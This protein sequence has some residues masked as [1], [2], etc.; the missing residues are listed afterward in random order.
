VENIMFKR[1][2]KRTVQTAVVVSFAV[3]ALVLGQ[4][5]DIA[6]ILGDVRKALGADKA[7]EVKTLSMTGRTQ[8]SRPDGTSSEFA[9][10]MFMELPDKF[11][12]RDVVAAMG[13]T[14]IY[15]MSG[16]NGDGLINE[17][18]TPPSLSTGGAM[19]RMMPASGPG[20]GAGR[21]QTAEEMEDARKRQLLNHRQD[22]ARLALGLFGSSSASYPVELTYG[23]EAESADGKAY[24]V[25]VKGEGN[26]V[27]KLFIDTR[28]NLPLMLSWMDKEPLQ[29]T[30]NAGPGGG[31]RGGGGG[32]GGGGHVVMAGGGHQIS[33][34]PGDIERMQKEM[35]ER[36]KEAEAK[37]RTVEYRLFYGDYKTFNGV[38]LPTR[39]QRMIDGSPTDEM[40]FER[41]QVNGK[42]D[43]KKFEPTK[44]DK[45]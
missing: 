33:G 30:M 8:R 4:G 6:K 21:P 9:F 5:H 26:F 42:I 23:G 38:K 20:S 31:T 12:K 32:A 34:N 37:R 39:I 45:K 28:T 27:A 1:F 16:F 2:L 29:L 19:I 11:M 25:N 44:T 22:F 24:V 35:D 15:R 14:S 41:V 40:T 13:P 36:I 18:D 43:P 7:A 10:E 3:P 17:V